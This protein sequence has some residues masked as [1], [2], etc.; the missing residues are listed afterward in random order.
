LPLLKADE[1]IE[2]KKSYHVI[3]LSKKDVEEIYKMGEIL[4][5]F[6]V[7][8]SFLR[9]E[10]DY[11]MSLCENMKKDSAEHIFKMICDYIILSW[12]NVKIKD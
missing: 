9:L 11:L 10:K 2:D 7:E 3:D 8:Q 12:E 4:E 6:A 1:L 5:L